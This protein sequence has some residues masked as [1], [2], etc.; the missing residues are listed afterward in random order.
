LQHVISPPF[1]TPADRAEGKDLRQIVEQQAQELERLEREL[2]LTREQATS[3]SSER[4]RFI[5]AATHDLLQPL[6]A[7]RLYASSLAER[8]GD[9]DL[10][11]L[12]H[13]IEASLNTVE[14]IMTALLDLARLDS[15]AVTPVPVEFPLAEL[16]RRLEV[17]FLPL[18]RALDVT[19]RT[20]PTALAVR[21]DRVLVGRIVQNL[22][23]N[24]I[25][26]NVPGGRVLVGVRRRGSDARLDIIDTGIGI[27]PAQQQLIFGEFTRLSAARQKAAGLGL[28]LSIVQRLVAALGLRIE[29]ASIPGRG[30]RFSLLLPVGAPE[31]PCP[32]AH[33]RVPET[34]LPAGLRVLCI[35][36]EAAILAALSALLGGWGCDVRVATS[37]K[38][39]SERGLLELWLPDLILMDYHL[40]QASGLDAI[41]WLRQT[42]GPHV[43]AA[44][45]TADHSESVRQLA[46]AREI[47]IL[48]KPVKPAALRSLV[49]ALTGAPA[50]P[51]R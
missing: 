2:R 46:Q 47:P 10:S 7:A 14:E 16:Q 41:E 19:L 1:E 33:A 4:T 29:I 6:S 5:A 34:G 21:G 12:A 30:S 25:K 38:S 49:T 18:A 35:D 13:G 28:G 39:V 17:E 44:L 26:Y 48:R 32:P 20:V 36:N 43:P 51:V 40:E 23:S 22:V 31:S 27:E 11:T 3:A 9:A 50:S 8:T 45:I 24:A 15:G 37:L 42:L